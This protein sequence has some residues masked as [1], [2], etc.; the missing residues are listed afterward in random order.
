VAG[1]KNAFFLGV[2][3]KIFPF[4]FGGGGGGGGG[5]VV[6]D[7]VLQSFELTGC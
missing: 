4:F 1:K 5:G 7:R 2:L 3:E 6:A